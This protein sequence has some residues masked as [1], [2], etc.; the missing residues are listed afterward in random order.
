MNVS[1]AESVY[2]KSELSNVYDNI[3][4]LRVINHSLDE[5]ASSPRTNSKPVYLRLLAARH[6]LAETIDE[7][8]LTL[9]DNVSAEHDK[10][11]G[12]SMFI[13]YTSYLEILN[14]DMTYI[15][16][17]LAYNGLSLMPHVPIIS[18]MSKQPITGTVLES[19]DIM[20]VE[21]NS[22]EY[23]EDQFPGVTCH[24]SLVALR[25]EH[26]HVYQLDEN[27]LLDMAVG[28]MAVNS[29]IEE[30]KEN[31]SMSSKMKLASISSS[32]SAVY[33]LAGYEQD[34]KL[35]GAINIA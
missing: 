31:D 34:D 5:H 7:T 33:P 6:S 24:L 32:F 20:I 21:K 30:L 9:S 26:S 3:A 13:A 10:D 22:K 16:A 1:M 17:N 14:D 15:A 11:K 12:L 23:I 8:L 28:S 19:P 29:Y 2:G 25:G 27:S 4:K 18:D 35:L